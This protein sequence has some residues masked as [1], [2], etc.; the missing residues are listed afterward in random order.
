[1]RPAALLAQFGKLLLQ[2]LHLIRQS[3]ILFARLA[4][5][6]QRRIHLIARRQIL[7][8]HPALEVGA[9]HSLGFALH[10]LRDPGRVGHQLRQ[11]VKHRTTCSH[12]MLSRTVV[13]SGS[14]DRSRVHAQ[15]GILAMILALPFP[16]IDPVLIAIG[17]L[18]IRWY[19]LAYIA[20]LVGGAVL[21]R[22]LVARADLWAEQRPPLRKDQ[23]VDLTVWM[24]LGVIAGGRLGYM[25]FY[26][27]A[28]LLAN[29]LTVFAL[30]QGGMSFHGGL[31]GAGLAMFWFSRRRDSNWLSMADAIACVAPLGL[32]LG[33]VANFINGELWGRPT[34]VPWAVIFPAPA[35]GGVPRHPSQLYEAFLEGAVLLLLLTLLARR[36][37]ALQRPGLCTGVFLMGYAVARMLVEQFRAP[38]EHLG[39]LLPIGGGGVTMGILLSVPMLLLGG[40]LVGVAL[41]RRAP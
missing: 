24:A 15:L 2:G 21:V 12:G 10:A 31:I 4:R 30:W 16:T 13:I 6:G 9:K 27:P 33:R 25:L 35:A 17:P 38:D 41:R 37:A 32:L 3:L 39:F 18:A 8:R 29:P 11:V 26:A 22:Q 14:V 20:G 19:S 34:D 5:H 23:V 40:A 1:M 28:S 7:L 36:S